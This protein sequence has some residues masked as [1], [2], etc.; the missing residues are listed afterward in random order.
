ML[1]IVSQ[2]SPLGSSTRSEYKLCLSKVSKY[3]PAQPVNQNALMCDIN[4]F[5]LS[6]GGSLKIRRFEGPA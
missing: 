6:D 4:L 5:F 3:D 1:Y 2:F